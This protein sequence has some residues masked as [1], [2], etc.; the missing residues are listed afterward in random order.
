MQLRLKLEAQPNSNFNA[1]FLL[2]S[3]IFNALWW[4]NVIDVLLIN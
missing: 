4:A 3:V 2:L 1:N